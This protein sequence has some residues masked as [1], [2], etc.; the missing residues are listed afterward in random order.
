MELLHNKRMCSGQNKAAPL[1]SASLF[2]LKREGV[3]AEEQ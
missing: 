2:C 1:R 3:R